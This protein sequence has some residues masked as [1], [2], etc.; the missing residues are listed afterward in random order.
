MDKLFARIRAILLT[1][2][3]EWPVIAEEPATIGQLVLGYVLPLALIP[4]ICTYVKTRVVGF[5]IPVLGTTFRMGHGTALSIALWQYV[6]SLVVV[7]VVAGLVNF[8]APTFACSRNGTQALKTVAYSFT[9]SWVAGLGVLLGPPGLLLA[10]LGAGYG[11]Y[12]LCVGLPV[13]ME[14]PP[15]RAVG[16]TVATLV[17][18]VVFYFVINV[19]LGSMLFA[20]GVSGLWSLEHA[21]SS[22]LAAGDQRA[23]ALS[24]VT[25]MLGGLGSGGSQVEALAPER[26]K[27]FLPDTM[28]GMERVEVSVQRANIGALNFGFARARYADQGRS[29]SLQISDMGSAQGL[30]MLSRFVKIEGERQSPGGNERS[31]RQDGMFV[32]KLWNSA[33][34]R[35]DY[36]FVVGDRFMVKVASTG[37]DQDALD[38]AMMRVDLAGLASL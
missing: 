33:A 18:A 28:D 22:P 20:R 38:E 10:L 4:V 36:D 19:T 21:H 11:V 25:Q 27:A 31:Y 12:L 5:S 9:A 26:L 6:L 23:A 2:K 14:C 32:H 16:Y 13:T 1:P 37:I 7:F 3:A 29:I 8:L 24:A 35:G 34:Q 17:G 30:M 15:D